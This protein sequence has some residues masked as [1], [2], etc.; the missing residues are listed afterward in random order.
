L[1]LPGRTPGGCPVLPF[2]RLHTTE[3]SI[4]LGN[5]FSI[6]PDLKLATLNFKEIQETPIRFVQDEGRPLYI[7]LYFKLFSYSVETFSVLQVYVKLSKPEGDDAY[8]CF[9]FP[10]S[11]IHSGY[12]CPVRINGC[13][14][15]T[16]IFLIIR[17]L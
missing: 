5:R 9:A 12:L 3:K 2:M 8:Q 1:A 10:V 14:V 11:F 6:D 15:E 7:I 16:F 4:I 17:C 13:H